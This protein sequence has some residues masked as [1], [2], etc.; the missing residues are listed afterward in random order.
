[1][2]KY[3]CFVFLFSEEGLSGLGEPGL[4]EPGLGEPGRVQTFGANFASNLRT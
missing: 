1:L 2:Q 4:G 3:P